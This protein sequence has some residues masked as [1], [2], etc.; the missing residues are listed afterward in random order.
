MDITDAPTNYLT[1]LMGAVVLDA[2]TYEEVETD[3]AATG[4]AVATVI[5]SGLAAGIGA[6]GVEASVAT[7]LFIAFVAILAWAFWA[8]ISFE[9]G[10]RIM[11]R[12]ETRSDV[13]ELLRT[14]GFAG[15]PGFLLV[16]GASRR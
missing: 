9:I 7:V 14:L 4:Q 12:S 2:S 1:R 8:V 5:L 10:V 6:R 16:F 15:A 11:R 13:E 3:P